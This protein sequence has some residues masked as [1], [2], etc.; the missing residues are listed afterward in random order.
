M[1]KEKREREFCYKG[2]NNKAN[3]IAPHKSREDGKSDGDT[4]ED[5]VTQMNHVLVHIIYELRHQPTIDWSR[6]FLI[7]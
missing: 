3:L 1:E 2:V 4:G 5:L 7:W 6:P